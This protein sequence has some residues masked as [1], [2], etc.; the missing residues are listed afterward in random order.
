MN[1]Y[2]L[3]FHSHAV[4]RSNASDE[5][6]SGNGTS[7]GSLLLVVGNTFTGKVGGTTLRDLKDD[8]GVDIPSGL[9]T[10]IDDGR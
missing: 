5:V 8:G 2:K 9:E 1:F 3:K 7:D 6:S 4:D 10:G